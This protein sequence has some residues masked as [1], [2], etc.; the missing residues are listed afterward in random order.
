MPSKLVKFLIM[1]AYVHRLSLLQAQLL[2]RVVGPVLRGYGRHIWGPFGLLRQETAVMSKKC[3][4]LGSKEGHLFAA[5][6][7]YPPTLMG[8]G[9]LA[10]ALGPHL[11][12]GMLSTACSDGGT[13][14]WKVLPGASENC[15]LIANLLRQDT[16]PRAQAMLLV[17]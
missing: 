15:A 10:M 11:A 2:Q 6:Y 7:L 17:M 16:R 3:R 1:A 13:S 8:S 4:D 12:R 5:P 14:M 9:A